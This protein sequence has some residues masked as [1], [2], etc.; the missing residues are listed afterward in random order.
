[1]VKT[2]PQVSEN[3]QAAASYVIA[4]Y[5]DIVMLTHTYANYENILIELAETYGSNEDGLSKMPAD[6]KDGVKTY[7]QTLRYYATK[8]NISYNALITGMGKSADIEVGTLYNHVLEQFIIKAKDIRSYV[9]K[10][11]AILMSEVIRDLLES[12]QDLVNKLYS[13]PDGATSEP[14]TPQE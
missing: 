4:F 8:C 11:N 9:I 5:N 13:G 3:R 7:C 14:T 10:L 12:S 6:Q 1:M 2:Q